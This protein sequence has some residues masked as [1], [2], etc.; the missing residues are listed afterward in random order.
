MKSYRPNHLLDSSAVDKICHVGDQGVRL[1]QET[2]F[3]SQNDYNP[4]RGRRVANILNDWFE[5]EN[6]AGKKLIELGPGHYAFALLAR[7]LGADVVCVERDPSFVELGRH[8]GFRVLDVDFNDLSPETLPEHF[9]GLWAKG[10]FNSA[11]AASDEAVRTFVSDKTSLLA[12]SGWAWFTTVNKGDDDSQSS[13]DF[14]THRMD[15]QRDAFIDCGWSTC[16][17]L[18]EERPLYALNYRGCPYVYFKNLP[19]YAAQS[20]R[21]LAPGAAPL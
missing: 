15:V 9:D 14:V 17:I 13:R 5:V 21:P 8:L 11:W 3:K 1:I 6:F 2:A 10:T 18:D 16:P 7:H 4:R 12:P 19:R 20:R